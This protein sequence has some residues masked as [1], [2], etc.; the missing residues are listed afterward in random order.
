MSRNSI[1][2]ELKGG[3]SEV[4]VNEALNFIKQEE[5]MDKDKLFF[6]V[7]W[8]GSPHQP[9]IADDQDKS[10][11]GDL[12][13]AAKN[14]YGELVEMDKSLGVLRRELR[15]LEMSKNT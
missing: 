7:I 14:H 13:E 6:A 1:F 4:V 10:G 5:E 9:W 2:E 15:N 3:S 11:F 8:F 12:E